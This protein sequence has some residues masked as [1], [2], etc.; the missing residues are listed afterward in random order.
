MAC[1]VMCPRLAVF[2]VF[3]IKINKLRL[4]S[5]KQLMVPSGVFHGKENSILRKENNKTI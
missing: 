3:K 1:V 4:M 5:T 2:F